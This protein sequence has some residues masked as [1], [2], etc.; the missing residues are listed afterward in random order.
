MISFEVCDELCDGLCDELCDEL[1]KE[2][3]RTLTL[4]SREVHRDVIVV[5]IVPVSFPDVELSKFSIVISLIFVRR[6]ETDDDDI[7]VNVV[8][9]NKAF[10]KLFVDEK[11]KANKNVP[12]KP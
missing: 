2:L 4:G 11:W 3:R 9:N 6:S 10:S 5:L 1:A 7:D 8:I 12:Q